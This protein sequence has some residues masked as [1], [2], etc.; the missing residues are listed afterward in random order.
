[1]ATSSKRFLFLLCLLSSAVAFR[2]EAGRAEGCKVSAAAG[3]GWCSG[4][5]ADAHFGL[6]AE[7][8]VDVEVTLPH[9]KRKVTQKGVKGDQ[10]VMVKK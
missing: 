9:N 10:R 8:V 7:E 5:E 6:G 2:E 1:M 3:Y 4:Q